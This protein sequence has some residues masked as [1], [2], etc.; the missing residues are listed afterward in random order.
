MSQELAQ[1]AKL[2]WSAPD[3]SVQSSPQ[4]SSFIINDSLCISLI[5]KYMPPQVV[6]VVVESAHLHVRDVTVLI[7]AGVS[8]HPVIHLLPQEPRLVIE[9]KLDKTGEGQ[10]MLGNILAACICAAVSVVACRGALPALILSLN[11]HDHNGV[12]KP[13]ELHGRRNYGFSES[14]LRIVRSLRSLQRFYSSFNHA[15]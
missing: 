8:L 10:V 6:D 2:G 15:I 14:L 9:F 13:L 11:I 5:G 1:V 4:A 7:S 12:C 3:K